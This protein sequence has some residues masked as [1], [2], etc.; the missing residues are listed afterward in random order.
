MNETAIHE[1]DVEIFQSG[2]N[3][4]IDTSMVLI[5]TKL[6]RCGQHKRLNCLFMNT[7]EIQQFYFDCDTTSVTSE[8][9]SSQASM[10][11]FGTL[12]VLNM[13]WMLSGPS[14]LIHVSA[15]GVL[16]Y[17]FGLKCRLQGHVKV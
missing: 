5:K 14:L 13:T 17:R 15:R 8:V 16:R 12:K 11:L 6:Q 3:S 9:A 10:S 1:I 4:W 2:P 7:F